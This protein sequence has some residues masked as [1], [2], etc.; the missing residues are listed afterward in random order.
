MVV[1]PMVVVDGS[2]TAAEEHVWR[3]VGSIH[4]IL[5][6]SEVKGGKFAI[7]GQLMIPCY[8]IY[9]YISLYSCV[10][11]GWTLRGKPASVRIRTNSK[12]GIFYDGFSGVTFF[13]IN[14]SPH[15]LL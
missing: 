1:V 12:P 6:M 5:N 7:R 9:I 10:M 3:G 13:V 15:L 2:R 14:D 8:L 11:V 4:L